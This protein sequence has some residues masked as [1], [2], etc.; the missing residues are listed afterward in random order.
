MQNLST[1]EDRQPTTPQNGIAPTF[2]NLPAPFV[3]AV[4]AAAECDRK[5]VA[6]VSAGR[7]ATI[8]TL[9]R[10]GKGGADLKRELAKTINRCA[11]DYCG[12]AES[13]ATDTAIVEAVRTAIAAMQWVSVPEI[14][15]AHQLA[16]AGSLGDV[17]MTAYGGRYS[18]E[19][20]GRIMA[21]YKAYRA[22]IVAA[23]EDEADKAQKI[24]REAGNKAKAE[25]WRRELIAGFKNRKMNW[26][27]WGDVPP[28]AYDILLEAGLVEKDVGLWNTV[29]SDIMADITMKVQTRQSDT[30][31]GGHH[32][33]QAILNK[34]KKDPDL[35]PPSLMDRAKAWYKK[36][37]VFA[38]YTNQ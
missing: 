21:A 4:A 7:A 31:L 30:T 24:A 19:L 37:A 9:E 17:Q 14:L 18:V 8:R 23:L 3:A 1:N 26:T 32:D 28:V 15:L 6:I 13:S 20:F 16:A 22:R 5:T 27:T 35:F 25:K 2:S 29:K 33:L 10:S 38:Q 12:A 11:V 36:R 34:W